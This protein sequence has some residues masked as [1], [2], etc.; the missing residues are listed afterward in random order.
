MR[1]AT[2]RSCVIRQIKAFRAIPGNWTYGHLLK[3]G[4]VKRN[5][6]IVIIVIG[7]TGIV[8]WAG[9]GWYVR[10]NTPPEPVVYKDI[11]E[12]E[13]DIKRL[14][15]LRSAGALSWQELYR[16]GVAYI[17]RGRPA[18]AVGVLEESKRRHSG[19]LKTYESLG[20]AY[21]RIDQP[22]KAV[23]TWEAA[24]KVDPKAAFLNEM[25]ERGRKK[26]DYS[27]RIA[28]LEKEVKLDKAVVWTK[29][30]ELA[31]LYLSIRRPTEARA[32]LEEILRV[33]KDV[34][35]VYD[36][37]AEA[38]ALQ[39]DF[40]KALEA[41]KKALKIKPKNEAFKKRV[42]EMESLA[43]GMRTAESSKR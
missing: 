17:Q 37:L 40:I 34:P 10:K 12:L 33:K 21:F 39:G 28:A 36:A 3:T 38:Y 27:S 32:T 43:K 23:E 15:S 35:E 26:M 7:V 19:F 41:E 16:L 18:E 20:M 14:E 9:Y 11:A 8:A 4:T 6:I 5:I 24:L 13:E 25:I 30:F 2:F 42:S 31:A 1:S 29:R 22:G